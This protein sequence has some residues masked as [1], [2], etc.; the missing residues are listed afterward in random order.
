MNDTILSGESYIQA[1]LIP[2]LNN[3]LANKDIDKDK[4]DSL[5]TREIKEFHNI[6]FY[7]NRKQ[8]RKEIQTAN[9]FVI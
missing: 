9:L 6:L 8:R 7:K 2:A 1:S 4:I 5:T 3:R